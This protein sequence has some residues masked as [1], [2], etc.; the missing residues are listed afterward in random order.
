MCVRRN[1][2]RSSAVAGLC[3]FF[4][5]VLCVATRDRRAAKPSRGRLCMYETKKTTPFCPCKRRGTAVIT[6]KHNLRRIGLIRGAKAAR[7]FETSGCAALQTTNHQRQTKQ[8]FKRSRERAQWPN[9]RPQL[10]GS[11]SSIGSSNLP[12]PTKKSRARAHYQRSPLCLHSLLGACSQLCRQSQRRG[13]EA[14]AG[15]SRRLQVTW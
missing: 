9:A 10:H 2:D 11:R 14:R 15:Y 8:P 13:S 3:L 4:F 12:T 7:F 6:E 1:E 5:G